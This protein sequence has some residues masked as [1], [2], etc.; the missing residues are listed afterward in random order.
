MAQRM[1]RFGKALASALLIVA[2]MATDPGAPRAQDGD[3]AQDVFED[4]ISGPIVQ[5]RCVN[6]HVEGGQSGHTRLLLVRESEADHEAHN[7]R[8]FENLLVAV[9]ND[10]GASYVLNKIQGVA[11]GGGP[12]V[13]A[14]TEEFTNMQRF[15]GLLGRH[16][17][18][19][20]LTP[21][22]LFDTVAM[23]SN[24]KTL[25]RAALIFAGRIPTDAEYAAVAGGGDSAL[26]R[27]IRDLM[28]GPGFHDFLIRGGNDRL[29]TDRDDGYVLDNNKTHLVNLT[30]EAHRRRK[31]AQ[32]G[33]DLMP[34]YDWMARVQHG[35]R[36]A[37]LELIAYVVENERPYTEILTADYIMANPWSAY[38]YGASTRFSDPEDSLEFRP[39]RIVAYH[40]HGEGFEE[41]YDSDVQAAYVTDPGSLVTTYPHAGVL[42]TT[43][44]LRRYPTTATNRNRARSRW[45]YYHF[46][47]ID[48]E[49]SASRTTDPVALADTS[50]PTMHNPACTVCHSVLDP[51]AGAF[52]N[53]GDDGFYK[54]QWGGMDSLDPLYKEQASR[55]QLPV[56]AESWS[57]REA[58]VWRVTLTAGVETLRLMFTNHFWDEVADEGGR[59]YLD[60]LDVVDDDGRVVAS[61]EFEDLPAPVA[62]W[63]ACGEAQSAQDGG[64]NDHLVLWGGWDDCVMYIDI[65]IAATGGYDVEVV[66]W[67]D[68]R[69]DRYHNDIDFAALSVV[70]SDHIYEEGDTWYRDMRTPGFD[71]GSP[72]NADTSL[73]WLAKRIAADPRFAAATVRFWWPA[74]M[75]SEVAESPEDA[76]DA[77][78]EGL[79]LAAG[80]QGAEVERLAR[81]FRYGFPGSSYKYNLKDLLVEIL[82]SDWFRADAVTDRDPVRRTALRDAGARRMLT[83][84]ELAS[85]TAAI[86]GVQWG[87]RSESG[88]WPMCQRF[89]NLLAGDYRLFY[90]GI[91][92]DGVTERARDMTSVMAGVAARHATMLSCPVVGRELYLLP[93][94]KRRL[95]AGIS[96]NVTSAP[97]IK[98]KLVELHEKL[99]GVEVTAESPDV[100]A[101]YRLFVDVM[102]RGRTTNDDWFNIW[103]CEFWKDVLYLEGILDNAIVELEDA[104]GYRYFELDEERRDDFINSI[105]YTDRHYAARAWVVVLTAMMMDYRY[106]YL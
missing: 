62:D 33:G 50:N 91:D 88:C 57:D 71:G 35:A 9:Q 60:R 77:D 25:R 54:D 39:S 13:V 24:R 81:G 87:R 83:P 38:A 21:Q 2:V 30:N 1:K 47:G 98:A 41:G 69:D 58:L 95:F 96:P 22:T 80:A 90:G 44:F 14:G 85:K 28:E 106:L 79:L 86:T 101:A 56:Q 64:G 70:A 45:A 51:L 20:S 72:L 10:G 89:S 76:S 40:R 19:A 8:A 16:V 59:A 66:A 26:P 12:Q 4:H 74:I 37:P 105:D 99:L 92:S 102:Q 48:V 34:F 55:E 73:Q 42:N 61:R 49:K 82:L 97:A 93:D 103:D 5:S 36:R 68:G 100:E 46:L 3:S 31:A 75:G 7:L 52:Q 27:A 53:Y 32:A 104:Y 18:T 11:H 6:C 67:S 65:D 29:L 15:L 43:V 84:E 94:A 17:A 23:A 78:F 63:G